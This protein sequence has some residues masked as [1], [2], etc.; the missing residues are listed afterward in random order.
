MVQ[1]QHFKLQYY[2]RSPFSWTRRARRQYRSVCFCSR[3]WAHEGPTRLLANPPQL[4]KSMKS[5]LM[6]HYEYISKFQMTLARILVQNLFKHLLFHSFRLAVHGSWS[7]RLKF[8]SRN[9]TE[10]IIFYASVAV[11][12]VET[13]EEGSA[14]NLAFETTSCLQLIFQ[15]MF[16]YKMRTIRLQLK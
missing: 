2:A 6:N 15:V 10:Q 13:Q 1:Y 7:W 3:E 8:S 11:F 12:Y 16:I 14:S 9:C 5:N 4:L